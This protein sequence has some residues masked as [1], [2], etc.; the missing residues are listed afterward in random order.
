MRYDNLFEP[1]S[2]DQ[3][4]GPDLLLEDDN[5]YIEYYF[6]ALDRIPMRFI[7]SSETG[8]VF[9]RKSID[10]K[11]EVA[12][13]DKLLERT[14]CLRLLSLEAQF[15]A[16]AGRIVGFCECVQAIEGLL[17]RFPEEVHPRIDEGD[18]TER[19]NA[20]ELLNEMSQVVMPLE[21]A[22]LIEDRR[23]GRFAFRDYELASGAKEPRGQ[24]RPVADS[25]AMLTALQSADNAAEVDKIY[26]ALAGARA[27]L[28]Q[29]RTHCVTAP[30]GA[31]G[32]QFENVAEVL[33]A[34]LRFFAEARPDLAGGDAEGAGD[35]TEGAEAAVA[36]AGEGATPD[37]AG[38]GTRVAS[39]PPVMVGPVPNHATAKAALR[40][41]EGYFAA[42]EPSAP[43]LLLIRQA[44]ALIGKPL[45]DALD[46]LLPSKAEEAIV[47][48]GS[49]EG[50]MLS[51][52]R[53]RELAMQ[54]PPS[55]LPVIDTGEA[56]PVDCQNRE[57]ATALISAVEGFFRKTEPSSPVPIL[58]FKAK[59]YL[60][61]D[62][63]SILSDLF[64]SA[65]KQSRET[66]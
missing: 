59:T 23:A 49:E 12:A 36:E 39:G 26:H 47:D 22:P 15:Q 33:D 7:I 6:E 52:G 17:A 27:A 16:L 32:P 37:A 13:I 2:A 4:C 65:H 25:G 45:T 42:I 43:S 30:S 46:A 21:H 54:E 19:R 28:D 29:I 35:G 31:F 14:R 63:S 1:I 61:R 20:L 9:D 8:E 56:E 24:E 40:A 53:L 18:S 11:A 10:I 62:F 51:V 3:P 5:D 58:L 41:V 34:I 55:D 50:F 48:F 64:Q 57:Q 44:Q 38:G 60:N 66:E